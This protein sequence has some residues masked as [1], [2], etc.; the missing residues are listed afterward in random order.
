[1]SVPDFQTM[2]L[3][4]LKLTE[5][6]QKH[7]VP[8]CVKLIEAEFQLS[9]TERE[10]R[11]PS[12]K[13]RKVYNRVTWA[14]THMKKAGLL[15]Y[16]QRGTISITSRGL[17]LLSSSPDK[18]T[19]RLLKQYPEY[20]DFISATQAEET[21]STNADDTL[22][23][24]EEAIGTLAEKLNLQLADDLLDILYKNSPAFF[25]QM[26]VDLLLKMGY[27]GYDEAGQVTGQTGDGGI[28]G[29]IQEDTLGLDSIYLQAKLWGKGV[30]VG[31]PEIQKFV[32]ALMGRGAS[33]GVF[34]TSSGFSPSAVEYAKSI[35]QAKIVL[36]DG[37]KLAKLMI[38]YDLGVSIRDAIHIKRIDS[39]YFEMI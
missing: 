21:L 19:T 20:R 37:L 28:D 13:Q 26:V 7:T 3:P 12:G 33:K 24:P 25:E 27:G 11:V 31:R 6:Q 2:M 22:Q 39:D 14:C 23:S 9:E 36:I 8:E 32:G 18:I 4:L 10:E 15:E 16:P 34:I 17:A 5:D 1:M 30:N 35:T 29:I 38:Q